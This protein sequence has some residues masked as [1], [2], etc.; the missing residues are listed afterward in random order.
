MRTQ[1]DREIRPFVNDDAKIWVRAL[2]HNN[3]ELSENDYIFTLL[4]KI[5][6]STSICWC[7]N[8]KA[9]YYWR[10]AW[11]IN[12]SLL[13][14]WSE[15]NWFEMREV[16]ILHSLRQQQSNFNSASVYNYQFPIDLSISSKL[17][18]SRF[19]TLFMRSVRPPRTHTHSKF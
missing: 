11:T 15:S 16:L 5:D 1:H 2:R 9:I 13:H 14:N 3:K 8:N 12:L 10:I 4:L 17:I 7:N 6:F 18:F 19:N